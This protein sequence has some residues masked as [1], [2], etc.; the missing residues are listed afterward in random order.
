[1]PHDLIDYTKKLMHQLEN[2]NRYITEVY[3]AYKVILY[4]ENNFGDISDT[5]KPQ[6]QSIIDN[7][8][9]YYTANDDVDILDELIEQAMNKTF[10]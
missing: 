9:E 1:M 4:Y 10:N 5:A 8:Y 7:I 2:D 6:L 3:I